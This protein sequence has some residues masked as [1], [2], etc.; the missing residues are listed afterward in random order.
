MIDETRE[1]LWQALNASVVQASR[2]T[3]DIYYFAEQEWLAQTPETQAECFGD[4][5]VWIEDPEAVK[6]TMLRAMRY[7]A[8]NL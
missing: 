4:C 8:E 1:D 7:L 5:C 2:D 6:A 3:I